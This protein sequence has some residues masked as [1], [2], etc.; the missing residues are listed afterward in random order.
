MKVWRPHSANNS[1]TSSCYL[2]SS[3]KVF[4]AE[5]KMGILQVNRKLLP[6]KVHYFLYNGA[7]AGVIAFISVYAKQLGISAGALGFIFASVSSFAVISRPLLGSLVDHFQR[8]KLVLVCLVLINIAADLVMNFIPQPASIP[9]NTI[10]NSLI[11][12]QNIS[13]NIRLRTDI[14]EWNI[15]FCDGDC[16]Y[17]CHRCK[18]NRTTCTYNSQTLSNSKL[19]SNESQNCIQQILANCNDSIMEHCTEWMKDSNDGS[20]TPENPLLQLCTVTVLTVL[21]YIC[22]GS[23]AS[24]SDAACY[25]ALGDRR[26]LYGKQRMWGTMGWGSFA[27]IAGYLNQL[28]T[29]SSSKYNFSAGF[30]MS[31]VLFLIDLLV[32]SKLKLENTKKSKHIFKD[33]G[34]LISKPSIILFLLRVLSV[35]IFRG[36]S[37]YYVFWYLRTLNASQMVLGCASAV[38]CF[39]GELP[40]FFLSGW[41]I[42]KIGH[43]NAFIVSFSSYGI[44]FLSYSY[45][46]NPWWSLLIEV[47]QGP[48]Y[49]CLYAAMTS[50]A[51]II[52]PVGTEA[53]VQGLASGTLEGL[54]VA[55]GCLLGGYGFQ[56]FGGRK[57]FFWTGMIAFVLAIVNCVINIVSFY[58]RTGRTDEIPE[59]KISLKA[60]KCDP[61]PG[62]II[63]S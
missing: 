37:S 45:I 46:V 2:T 58:R 6:V 51:K 22:M 13:Y 50:Y 62:D 14:C 41:I 34:N 35:G 39:L 63:T 57:T 15:N 31:I 19:I 20:I 49:G 33:V 28:T 54:G 23:L 60:Q 4:T 38:L 5:K 11:C 9:V 48:C 25:N 24:L 59:L 10:N 12:H 16:I 30:F 56:N 3:R 61:S 29:G 18:F 21:M 43:M 40:F 27:F 17:S 55:S 42:R 32:I 44:K 7:L 36:M 1:A 8:L 53:T 52:S 26:D 47:L